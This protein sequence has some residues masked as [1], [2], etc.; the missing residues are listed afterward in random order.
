M[1]YHKMLQSKFRLPVTA[2]DATFGISTQR[3]T[4]SILSTCDYVRYKFTAILY[5]IPFN[6]SI[7]ALVNE[8]I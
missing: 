8:I 5:V 1:K 2:T 4:Y 7:Q 3:C 6:N